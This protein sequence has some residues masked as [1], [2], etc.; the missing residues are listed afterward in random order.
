M[1]RDPSHF[2]HAPLCYI[3]KSVILVIFHSVRLEFAPVTQ[4]IVTS[5]SETTDAILLTVMSST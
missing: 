4:V 2:C 5:M 1:V 3:S